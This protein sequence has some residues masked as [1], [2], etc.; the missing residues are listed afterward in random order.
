MNLDST[1]RIVDISGVEQVLTVREVLDKSTGDTYGALE[2]LDE[3][4]RLCKEY[5]EEQRARYELEDRDD[6]LPLGS[7]LL[8]KDYQ[9]FLYSWNKE[10]ASREGD[11]EGSERAAFKKNWPE[12]WAAYLAENRRF[13]RVYAAE[14]DQVKAYQA[15]H[16]DARLSIPVAEETPYYFPLCYGV[17][18]KAL[19]LPS[20]PRPF[21]EPMPAVVAV[22]EPVP[23]V[24]AVAEPV[25]EQAP[26]VPVKPRNPHYNHYNWPSPL[27]RAFV[28][29]IRG[30]NAWNHNYWRF[31]REGAWPNDFKASWLIAGNTEF[32]LTHENC[33]RYLAYRCNCSVDEFLLKKPADVNSKLFSPYSGVKGYYVNRYYY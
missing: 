26:R 6:F 22:A 28:Q 11:W 7:H 18:P 24:V 20:S 10:I 29:Q 33:L 13:I 27:P 31:S 9:D 30:R 2:M 25:P 5:D 1:V 32:K 12:D 3:W 21:A 17:L 4:P 14:V 23:A 19:P 8:P 15:E 16:K